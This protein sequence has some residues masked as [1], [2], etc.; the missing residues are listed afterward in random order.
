MA[1]GKRWRFGFRAA[2]VLVGGLV[3][4]V[5]FLIVVGL[6]LPEVAGLAAKNP[7]STSLMR[8]REAE[9][10]RTGAPFSVRQEWIDFGRIPELMK[11]AVLV[12]EDAAFYSHKG[13]DYDELKAAIKQ[14]LRE[15]RFVR[16]ASTITQQ[17]AKNLFL[18]TDKTLWRKLKELW[19]TRRLEKALPKNRIFSLYL[20]LIEFGPGVFGV[21]AAARHWFGKSAEDLTLEEMVRLTAIISRPLRADPRTNDAWM[22]FKG[23]WIANTLKAANA[24]GEEERQALLLS[25]Q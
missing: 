4:L 21:Q 16:G 13:V 3:L 15:K 11:K 25:F 1:R 6:T 8:L 9:A 7:P 10:K 5:V 14:D 18:S 12:S 23:V 17:L 22:K 20:N 2:A 19:L 24:I